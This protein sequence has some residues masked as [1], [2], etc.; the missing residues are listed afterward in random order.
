[1]DSQSRKV[2][3][4]TESN[5][6]RTRGINSFSINEIVETI[7]I[8]DSMAYESVGCA[9]NE[10]AKVI[11]KILPRFKKGGRIIYVGA[12]TSGRIAAQD[13]IE[14]WPTY[15]LGNDKFEF[16]MA[17]G[18]K[19][20]FQAVEGAEDDETESTK[21]LKE[22]NINPLDTIIG[23]S[24]SG[25]T[26]FVK[27]AI[28]FAKE[29]GCYTVAIVNNKGTIIQKIA[30][31]TI[32]LNTG[33]EVIQGSTRMKAGTAQKMTLN[34][35]STAI[36]IKFGRTYDN[37]MFHLKTYNNKLKKRAI[38]LLLKR[39]NISSNEAERI[40]SDTGYDLERATDIIE[41]R[42]KR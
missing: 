15:G 18:K 36:A 2:E 8:E 40:L 17:G 7:H 1:M 37:M 13:A 33:P 22:L 14:M 16:I 34:I 12:G 11:N 20:L 35:I 29:N 3:V 31:D 27:S 26:P 32:I 28:Q 9:K 10:I 5:N 41:K 42:S 30:T 21:K 19:A 24:A 25:M 6:L 4:L 39:F 23:I 38:N